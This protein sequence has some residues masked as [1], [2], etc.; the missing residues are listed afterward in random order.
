MITAMRNTGLLQ[1]VVVVFISVIVLIYSFEGI[2]GTR[3]VRLYL[4][5]APIGAILM[6]TGVVLK[7]LYQNLDT[8]L[9]V[10]FL[11]LSWISTIFSLG[12]SA[13]FFTSRFFAPL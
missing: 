9:I 11:A 2:W 13:D 1:R 6:I 3:D 12:L 8:C 7:R 4:Y 10:L 5:M